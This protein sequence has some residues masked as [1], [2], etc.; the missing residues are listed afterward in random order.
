MSLLKMCIVCG[1][2]LDHSG[3]C[4]RPEEHDS[5]IRRS[6][7]F[8][9]PVQMNQRVS[10]VMIQRISETGFAFETPRAEEPDAEAEIDG[11]YLTRDDH[12]IGD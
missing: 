11:G 7:Q 6:T 3:H 2:A 5:L 8:S 12:R 10:Q 1:G 9:G 4:S